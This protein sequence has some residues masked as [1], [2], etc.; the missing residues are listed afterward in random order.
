MSEQ[1][2]AGG[3]TNTQRVQGGLLDPTMMWRS[4]P[5]ALRKLDPRTLWHNP[6]MFI[7]EVGAVWASVLAVIHDRYF[8]EQ[9]ATEMW[10]VEDGHIRTL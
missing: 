5:D 1:T 6:V 7:V 3:R 10:V 2:P 8:I 9:F 4:A